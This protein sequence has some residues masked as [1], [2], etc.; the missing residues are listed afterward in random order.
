M[1]KSKNAIICMIFI[2]FVFYS[3]LIHATQEPLF[4][5]QPIT[6]EL[7][8]PSRSTAMTKTKNC[9]PT[10]CKKGKCCCAYFFHRCIMCCGRMN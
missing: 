4:A 7:F 1:E 6:F 9:S 3:P 5:P 2:M 8:F 10:V